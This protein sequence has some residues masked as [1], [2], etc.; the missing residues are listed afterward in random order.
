MRASAHRV[1]RRFVAE[2][3]TKSWLMGVR[4]TWLSLLKAKPSG[5]G[6]VARALNKLTEFLVNLEDEAMF[7]RRSGLS[8]FEGESR[9]ALKK[10]FERARAAVADVRD[11]ARFWQEIQ[12]GTSSMP[13]GS[14]TVEDAEKALRA[15]ETNFESTL[16]ITVKSRANPKKNQWNS[17]RQGSV[18]ELV[19][20]I[21]EVLRKEAAAIAES[22][23]LD[24]EGTRGMWHEPVYKE[25]D[26]HGMK[27]VL[28]DATMTAVHYSRYLKYLDE[29]YQ[30]LRAKGFSKVW[31]GTVFIKCESCGGVNPNGKSFGVGGDYPIGPD[32]VNI[33]SR[34]D[35]SI[36]SLLIH[37]L[38]HRYWY[39][40][41]S[42]TQRERFK[43]MIKMHKRPT[44]AR[45]GIDPFVQVDL[46]AAWL[47]DL[48]DMLSQIAK[49]PDT[50]PDH[51]SSF[52]GWAGLIRETLSNFTY[53]TNIPPKLEPDRRLV[54]RESDRLLDFLTDSATIEAHPAEAAA[55]GLV[56]VDAL[57]DAARQYVHRLD[58]GWD[59]AREDEYLSDTYH[60]APVSTYGQ[61]NP[62][63]AFAEAFSYFILERGMT[64]DQIES[65]RSVLG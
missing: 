46:D 20:D 52:K 33:Y 29:A 51:A 43:S 38:G 2:V 21:L 54:M 18:T 28:D 37:E 27:V 39:K 10:L 4:R 32:V 65:F 36:P 57:A 31:Y 3:L 30:K 16:T 5:W 1:A 22:M 8:S 12:T 25:F 11:G 48:R 61:S 6:Q 42:N 63:E 40:G 23:T 19:D 64:Q 56:R 50:A 62:D 53:T 24:P 7:T 15:F 58:T 60:V 34:P 41:M 47:N 17:H 45:R 55:A 26:F 35:S 49:N 59:D 14:H 44:R 9:N 13:P